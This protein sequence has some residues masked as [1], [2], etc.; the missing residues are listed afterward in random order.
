MENSLAEYKIN[1]RESQ[2]LRDFR[3]SVM[4]AT[5]RFFIL[6]DELERKKNSH[7]TDRIKTRYTSE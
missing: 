5:I 7:L 1:D 2:L 3:V 6:A 4:H